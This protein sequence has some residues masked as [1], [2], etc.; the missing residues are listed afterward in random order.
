MIKNVSAI[1]LAAGQS[2]R[3]SQDKTFFEIDGIP[4]A[5]KSLQ[6]ILDLEFIDDVIIVSSKENY[7]KFTNYIKDKDYYKK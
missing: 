3:F 1:L 2:K 5:I 6:T 7:E 4:I